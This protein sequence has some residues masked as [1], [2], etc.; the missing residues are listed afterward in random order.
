M[1]G[2]GGAPEARPPTPVKTSLKK[3]MAAAWGHKFRESSDKF[4]DTILLF[5]VG[6]QTPD[7]VG[8]NICLYIYFFEN[9]F[10][11]FKLAAD[12]VYLTIHLCTYQ[13]F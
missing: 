5:I 6:E 9:T 11:K 1:G 4:V 2:G 10:K 7:K 13:Y 3:K 8:L 12:S